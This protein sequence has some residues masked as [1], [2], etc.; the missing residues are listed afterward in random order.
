MDLKMK[1][2]LFKSLLLARAFE[3]K[4]IELAEEISR[5]DIGPTSCLG[6]EAIPVGFCF[7]LNKN[8]FITPSI[9][10]A[11]AAFL[12]K[13]I[14]ARRVALEMYGKA[15]GFSDGRELSSHITCPELGIYGGTGILANNVTVT[16]GIA[17]AARYRKSGQVAICFTGDGASNREEFFTGINFAALRKLP[18]IF[19]VEN[20]QIA[21]FTPYQKFMPVENIADRASAFAIPGV[22]VDGNDLLAVYETACEAILRAREGKGPTLVECKTCRVRPMS[23][24]KSP[25][26]GLPVEVIKK[27]KERD[28]VKIME[29]HLRKSNASID[30][31]ITAMTEKCR[32]EVL[33]AFEFARQ[34]PYS[35]PKVVFG[36]VYAEG[37]QVE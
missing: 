8:D 19:V 30:H 11:W 6:Q 25:D 29:E 10:S 34:S 16:S 20:N 27:W 18:A 15:G 21:E 22:I 1:L 28:P 14:S 17:L 3:E 32:Q 4:K 37:G 31:E 2:E 24:T 7:G 36:G 5:V 9:R 35:S 33:E 23:E 26:K 13:G 12:T